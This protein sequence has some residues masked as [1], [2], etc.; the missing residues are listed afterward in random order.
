MLTETGTE[1][2]ICVNN[3]LLPTIQMYLWTYFALYVCFVS[4]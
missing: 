1:N 4:A 2:M 3:F